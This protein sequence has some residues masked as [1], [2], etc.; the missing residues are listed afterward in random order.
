MCYDTAS[1]VVESCPLP[2]PPLCQ[3]NPAVFVPNGIGC[4]QVHPCLCPVGI[5]CHALFLFCEDSL[6]PNVPFGHYSNIRHLL[7]GLMA[8]LLLVDLDMVCVVGA[9][10]SVVSLRTLA[11]PAVSVAGFF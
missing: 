1:C 9:L 7:G 2:A 8:V 11:K 3:V 4:D 10:C 6:W 5:L